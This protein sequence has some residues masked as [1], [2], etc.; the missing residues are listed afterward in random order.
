MN[1]KLPAP[2]IVAIGGRSGSVLL[3]SALVAML[4]ARPAATT[5]QPQAPRQV[6]GMPK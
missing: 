1:I 6:E 5:L 4:A 3:A 2:P